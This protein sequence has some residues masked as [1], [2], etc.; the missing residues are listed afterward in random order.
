MAAKVGMPQWMK[1]NLFGELV[2]EAFPGA[3]PYLVG[4][5]ARGKDWRDVDVRVPLDPEQWERFVGEDWQVSFSNGEEATPDYRAAHM[6]AITNGRPCGRRR[7]ALQ[8]AFAELGLQMTGLP[9]DF[10]FQV[11][12]EHQNETGPAIPIGGVV[13]NRSGSA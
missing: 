13:G 5:A 3:Q 6:E 1:L 9:I 8:L 4:S 10:Q 7:T 12:A 2:R 11:L